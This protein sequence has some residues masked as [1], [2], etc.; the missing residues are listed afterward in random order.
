MPKG[1]KSLDVYS[2]IT[3]LVEFIG[4][5]ETDDEDPP[6]SVTVKSTV[7]S[8]QVIGK[9]IWANGWPVPPP[10]PSHISHGEEKVV[11]AIK[12]DDNLI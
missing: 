4:S 8:S 2:I 9:S 5:E 3:L 6:K 12:I 10:D 11:S 7:E 1:P